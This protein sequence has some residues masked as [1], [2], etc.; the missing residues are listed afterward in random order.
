MMAHWLPLL[1]PVDEIPQWTAH[2]A[3]APA[4]LPIGVV[5]APLRLLLGVAAAELSLARRRGR[6]VVA[7]MLLLPLLGPLK[8]VWMALLPE[9]TKLPPVAAAGQAAALLRCGVAQ[10]ALQP[11]MN[12]KSI[13]VA[14]QQSRQGTKDSKK[15]KPSS[16]L[17]SSLPVAPPPPASDPQTAVHRC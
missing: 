5:A 13:F 15:R 12:H 6:E 10:P 1:P 14:F 17:T 8:L 2:A 11:C 7:E 9:K 16:M 3:A 4:P